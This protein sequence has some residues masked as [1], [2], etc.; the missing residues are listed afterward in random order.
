MKRNALDFEPTAAGTPPDARP[1][2]NGRPR[3]KATGS[4]LREVLTHLMADRWRIG[5]VF[6][7]G[8]VLTVVAAYLAP[9]HYVADASLLLRLGR[10]YIYTPEVGSTD[11]ATPI[12][13]DREQSQAAESRILLSRDLHEAVLDKL[14][15][16]TVYPELA[17]AIPDP[18]KRRAQALVAFGNAVTAELLKGSNLLQVSFKHKDAEMSARVLSQLVEAYLNKRIEV[19]SR[20][21]RGTVDAEFSARKAELTR[22]EAALATFKAQHGISAFNEEMSLLLAQRNQLDQRLTDNRLSVAQASGRTQALRNGLNDLRGDVQLMSETQRSDAVD[23]AR[24]LLVDL[25]L[26][27]RDLSSKFSDDNFAVQDI[28]TDIARTEMLL[29][30][31]E[32]RPQRTVRTGRNPARDAT[33]TDLVRTQAD[34]S[35]ASAGTSTLAT[36]RAAIDQRINVLAAAEST[37][38][39]LERDRRLAETTYEAAAKRQRDEQALEALDRQQRSNVSIVQ[40]PR[41]PLEAKSMR[42]AILL[43]GTVL[44]LCAALAAAFIGAALRDTFL[45]PEELQRGLDVPLLA[46]IPEQAVR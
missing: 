43:F 29:R 1:A 22:A 41:V 33:E 39:T 18:A 20:S 40:S 13:Y 25:R 3:P 27:E 36:Q 45:T 34:R 11:N 8:L 32:A 24:N 31:Y 16:A 12:A 28:R 2:G 17:A 42:P 5:S 35:Q 38:R 37:L 19:F 6:L 26:K 15:D 9:K 21:V 4:S 7:L 30:E 10:E 14:G 44:S 23:H 46:A